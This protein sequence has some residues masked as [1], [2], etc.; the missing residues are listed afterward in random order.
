MKK[1]LQKLLFGSLYLLCITNA[2]AQEFV[3]AKKMGG[4]GSASGKSV[5]VDASGNI[6]TTGQFNGTVDFDPGVGVYNLTTIGDYDIFVS[7]LDAAG[8]FVWAKSIGGIDLDYGYDIKVDALGNVYTTGAFQGTADF[9]PGPGVSSLTAAAFVLNIFVSKLDVDGNFVWA[10][11]IGGTL[12]DRGYSIFVDD[13]GNVYTTGFFNGT[14]DFDPGIGTT[15]LMVAGD[16]DIFISKLDPFGNFVWAKRMGGISYDGG[17]SITGDTLGNVYIAGFFHDTVD[18]DPGI[19]ITNL[20]SKGFGDMF[21]SKLD[22][23]GNF[24][25]AK[26]IGGVGSDNGFS[27][28]VDDFGNVY[29]TG[30]FNDTVDF[31]PGIGIFNLA[32]SGLED[33]FISKLDVNGNFVWAKSIGGISNEIGMSIAVDD[34]G[35]VYATGIFGDT[36]D[37]DPGIGIVSLTALGNTDIFILKLDDSGNFVWVKSLGGAG[38]VV[39][40]GNAITTDIYGNIYTTGFFKNTVDFDPGVGTVNLTSLGDASAFILKLSHCSSLINST[41]SFSVTECSIYTIPSGDETYIAEGTYLVMDTIPNSCGADSVMTI[42]V[43]ILPAID[44]STTTTGFVITSNQTG[45]TYQWIDCTNGNFILVGETDSNYTATTDGN[46]AVVVTLNGCTDTSS[47]VNISTVGVNQNS[48]NNEINIYPNPAKDAITVNLGAVKNA[49]I[50]I[51]NITGQEVY[52]LENVNEPKTVISLKE[53]NKGI[54]FVKVKNGQQQQE[55]KLIK[56]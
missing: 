36:C 56:Q 22:G 40:R 37:F 35:N 50:S 52:A 18:F 41:A 5:A 13:F 46:Y 29:T 19:G 31:D 10:K 26:S 15:N 14:V 24:V 8:N 20:I 23:S 44:I 30:L 34:L 1:V 2:N 4:I 43:T 33:V 25:W 9:D 16:S 21:I 42:S 55:L 45:A 28:F 51:I 48:N 49:Q 54:Y 32:S 17:H 27:I 38:F 3:W 12:H 53:L 6:Y 47:C 7:K 39:E 11:N